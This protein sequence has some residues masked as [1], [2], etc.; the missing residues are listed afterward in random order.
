MSAEHVRPDITGRED[1]SR[2]V[3]EFYRR[4]FADDLLG[5]VFVDIARVDLSA[6]LPA[7]CDFWDTV[8]LGAGRYRRNALR[9]H[10]VLDAEVTLTHTHFARWPALWAATVDE[11]H[12]GEKAEPAKVQAN[13]IAGSISRR[14]R[15]QPATEL[16]TIRSQPPDQTPT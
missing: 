8:L 1:I 2:L 10:I 12:A 13:R 5:P 9:P 6:H 14:L 3:A 7:M 15:G 11:Q 16:V 4:A